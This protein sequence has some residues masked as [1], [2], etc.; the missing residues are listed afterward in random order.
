MPQGRQCG[1]AS[2]LDE[3]P[4][5]PRFGF[6]F[7]AC[8]AFSAIWIANCG[9]ALAK[10]PHKAAII[11]H[12]GDLLPKRFHACETCHL[13]DEA[14]AKLDEQ[15]R[16]AEEKKPWN[17]FGRGLRALGMEQSASLTAG[18]RPAPIIERMRTIAEKDADGD[19]VANELELVAGTSPGDSHDLPAA[20]QLADATKRLAEFRAGQAAF[21]WNPFQPVVRPEVPS[22]SDWVGNPIDSFVAA[23]HR[24]LGL[25]PRPPATNEALLR[26][27][28]LD[29]VGLPPTREELR[30]FLS[31][32]S[33]DAYERVVDCLLASPQYGER[34][35][36]HWMD[37]WRYSDWAGWGQQVRDSQP[38]IWRWRDWII[39]SLNSDKGYDQM[40]LE[41]LAAD[42]H[43]PGNRD[44]LRATG[45][46]VR[47]YKRLSREQWLTDTVDH[48]ARAF[49]G[50]TL[51]CAQ[52]HDHK[53]DLLSHEEY[54]QF[55]AIFE[56]Y[57]VRIDPL[58][59]ELDPEKGGL[60]RVY[61][62]ALDAPT[63]L[64]LNGDERKPDKERR[65][66]PAAPAFIGGGE[67]KAEAVALPLESYYP[68]I[69]PFAIEE[70]LAKARS[71]VESAKAAVAKADGELARAEL[72]AAEAELRSLEARIAAE[73]A[74]H[75]SPTKPDD[76]QKM[77]AQTAG[78]AE[79]QAT[80]AK[81]EKNLLAVENQLK[82]ARGA[83]NQDEK[84][85]KAVADLET[86]TGEARKARDEAVAS[87]EKDT[88][89]YSPL[90]P[91]YPT[92]TTGRRLALARWIANTRNPLT[93]R[94]AV[95][96]IWARHFGRALV[97]TTDEFGQNRGEPSHP[98]L[99][100]WLAAELMQPTFEPRYSKAWSMKH[101]HRLIVTSNTF[102]TA[103]THD[104][105]NAAIDPDN[106]YLWR[107]TPRRVEAE[108]IRDS[109]L[110]VAGALDQ[111]LG[112]PELDQNQGLTSPR[113]SLYFR[114]A[115]EKQ[116]LFLQLF[117]MA[118]PGECY[119]RRESV[120]PQQALAL[121]N[122]ELT[123]REARRLARR[124]PV[125]RPPDPAAYVRS[126]FEQVLSRPPTSDEE[127][128][129]TEFLAQRGTLYEQNAGDYGPTTADAADLSKPAAEA[130]TRAR[131]NLVHVLLN[132]H[133]FVSIP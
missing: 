88:D 97:P 35:G 20:E 61:D 92:S 67:L 47:N 25:K 110:Y 23:E 48:T 3:V 46:L 40:V 73:Q 119:E 52:C 17:D 84:V 30:A 21:A 6:P 68:A 53:Y 111:T 63:Y 109:V 129:C 123:V 78:K 95:N 64:Y 83:S 31:D 122:S 121:A 120:V 126:A 132:H 9:L 72:A 22:G 56:P 1:H 27:V 37:I 41:M 104:S 101:L 44:A 114:S 118:A 32:P 4:T 13:S 108:V 54:Y 5:V 90:G 69:A 7:V 11:R 10:P 66:A 113:R 2:Q 77:L 125:G 85:K 8:A 93:A 74:K 70:A 112:G 62:A 34:W 71:N 133:D 49:L 79:R 33:P 58:K 98:A 80:L 81:A 36:R 128:A 76:E 28:Y 105:A 15:E 94:V 86:K 96:H 89:K 102:R 116:M 18:G 91:V 115:P 12:Y 19:G 42:E 57:Q 124:L 100:D 75:V 24:R 130:G 29:L 65:M 103:S 39:E 51:K 16:N 131:E 87:L 38:H 26:R 43:S 50:I 107:T 82:E 106:H 127:Q 60:A 45:F 59:G 117:D 14:V 55:R 99:V